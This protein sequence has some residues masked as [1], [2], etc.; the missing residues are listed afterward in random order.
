MTISKAQV[1]EAYNSGYKTG[2]DHGFSNGKTFAERNLAGSLE[3]EKTKLEFIKAMTA[4]LQ[5]NANVLEAVAH[6]LDN[7]R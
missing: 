1:Q 6:A 3:R 2:Q 7:Y 5:A 4:A